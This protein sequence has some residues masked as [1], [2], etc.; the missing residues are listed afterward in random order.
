[1]A[2]QYRTCKSNRTEH[3]I[4]GL[5]EYQVRPLS[6]ISLIYGMKRTG[7]LRENIDDCVVC[8]LS[9][10]CIFIFRIVS[11]NVLVVINTQI[12]SME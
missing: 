12:C 8:A 1:M 4:Y 11:I 6:H 3:H 2:R 7:E 5:D 10:V 9:S